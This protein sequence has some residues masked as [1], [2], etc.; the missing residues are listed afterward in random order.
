MAILWELIDRLVAASDR[1]QSHDANA[2]RDVLRTTVTGPMAAVEIPP[3][4]TTTGPGGVEATTT[5][6]CR[7]LWMA[8]EATSIA[9]VLEPGDKPTRWPHPHDTVLD[10]TAVPPEGVVFRARRTRAA[11]STA[12]WQFSAAP[13]VVKEACIV[14]IAAYT[15]VSQ[16]LDAPTREL[17]RRTL[18]GALPIPLLRVRL[19]SFAERFFRISAS[20]SG[21]ALFG[22]S[23]RTHT[24][25]LLGALQ[26]EVRRRQCGQAVAARLSTRFEI[27]A[28]VHTA[29][30]EAAGADLFGSLLGL[31][32]VPSDGK[33]ARPSA[34]T[35]GR[36]L[37][38]IQSIMT[39]LRLFDDSLRELFSTQIAARMAKLQPPT[40]PVLPAALLGAKGTDSV[41]RRQ[42]G[43]AAPDAELVNKVAAFVAQKEGVH[44]FSSEADVQVRLGAIPDRLA[45]ALVFPHLAM[46]PLAVVQLALLHVPAGFG[47]AEASISATPEGSSVVQPRLWRRWNLP[48][49][50]G[51]DTEHETV[52]APSWALPT[53]LHR[54]P[55]C[56]ID[57]LLALGQRQLT[58]AYRVPDQPTAVTSG[59]QA[60]SHASPSG[61]AAAA[62]SAAMADTALFYSA[63]NC[64]PDAL[65]G[66]QLAAQLMMLVQERVGRRYTSLKRFVT[67]SPVP[68]LLLWLRTAVLPAIQATATLQSASHDSSPA[69]S[70]DCLPVKLLLPT[71]L[72]RMSPQ[73]AARLMSDVQRRSRCLRPSHAS[74]FATCVARWTAIY[75]LFQKRPQRQAAPQPASRTKPARQSES[76]SGI[77][78][79]PVSRQRW[80]SQKALDP[81]LNFHIQNGAIL[82]R[83][84]PA[85][86]NMKQVSEG[87][88]SRMSLHR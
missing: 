35:D 51:D 9:A 22:L 45:F 33:A 42:A 87:G 40:A 14:G 1:L 82:A 29:V 17:L 72:P 43:N 24:R 25:R 54:D 3:D 12:L 6:A 49:S 68:G 61:A 69:A 65:Q 63:T 55:A 23:V 44:P 70:D 81:V 52:T 60:R 80:L 66:L 36:T 8:C 5:T 62:S 28:V 56:C 76:G 41:T 78:P 26:R 48:V 50:E 59:I 31:S 15:L 71:H 2:L 19:S 39:S 83:I 4:A 30:L 34:S 84:L 18:E 67:L 16:Q 13:R 11:A 86:S 58:A 32:L 10:E 20:M 21:G 57:A 37:E 38:R 85:A 73:L 77:D 75:L 7:W 47:V 88:V 27:M 79:V 64:F 53:S 74:I 46:Q